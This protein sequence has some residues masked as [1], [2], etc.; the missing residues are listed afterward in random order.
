VLGK[1]K[2][3]GA[4]VVDYGSITLVVGLAAIF[5]LGNCGNRLEEAGPEGLIGI[6]FSVLAVKLWHDVR[7][8]RRKTP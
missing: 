1:L 5:L 8:D 4:F 7:E 3:V 2:C 6:G